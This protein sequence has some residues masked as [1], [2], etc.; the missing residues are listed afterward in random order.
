[1][2]LPRIAI[3]IGDPA[4]VGAEIALKALAD[5]TTAGLAHWILIGDGAAL[6]AA[7]RTS[8]IGLGGLT[9]TLAPA[10]NLPEGHELGFGELRAEYG[11]AAI[12]YVRRAV[13]MCLA[14]DADAMVTAP[15]N[16]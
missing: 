14:G 13:E 7:A 10:P 16:K 12:D 11:V 9:C 4:G 2:K 3:T 15:L 1:M 8:G 6:E 5:P